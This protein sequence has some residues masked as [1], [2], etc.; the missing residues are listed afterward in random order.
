MEAGIAEIAGAALTVLGA[1]G[2]IVLRW[3]VQQV[4]SV[5]ATIADDLV[6]TLARRLAVDTPDPGAHAA[7]LSDGDRVLGDLSRRVGVEVSKA[8]APLGRRLKRLEGQVARVEVDMCTLLDHQ[9]EA[10]SRQSEHSGRLDAVEI[11]TGVYP[12]EPMSIGESREHP[13]DESF[14]ELR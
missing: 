12:I 8:T 2:L 13:L 5:R 1:L 10:E 4:R 3:A 11:V 7:E 9:A 14:E 6:R